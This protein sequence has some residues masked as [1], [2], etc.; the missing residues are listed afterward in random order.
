MSAVNP[1][2]TAADPAE[3]G[4]QPAHPLNR[5]SSLHLWMIVPMILMQL[6]IGMD[7]WGKFPGI[8]WPIHVH[9]WTATAWYGYLIAQPWLATHGRMAAHRTNGMIGL[10]IA[11][12]VVFTALSMMART[13]GVAELSRNEPDQFGPFKPEFF[14]G[15]AALEVAMMFLFGVAVV[16]SI[17]RRKQLED[18]AWWLIVTVFLIMA[19]A[20]GRGIQNVFILFQIDRW[21]HISLMPAAYLTQ[22]L[23]LVM[24]LAAAS[25][26]RKL[27]HPATYL[28]VSMNVAM[29]FVFQIGSLPWLQALLK[30]VFTG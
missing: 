12:G 23:I 5:Y 26:Y 9:Y 6:G 15:V 21:P 2:V 29:L 16:M 8:D 25:K 17:L 13:V 19:S 22:A 18:H 3:R 10:F 14:Y 1:T 24:I 27:S 28:A 7:Y 4:I 20:L 30:S 11:G